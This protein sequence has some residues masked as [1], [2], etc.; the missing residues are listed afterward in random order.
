MIIQP[1]DLNEIRLQ[2]RRGE[3]LPLVIRVPYAF[4]ISQFDLADPMSTMRLRGDIDEWCE[5]NDVEMHPVRCH[6]GASKYPYTGY[7]QVVFATE[8]DLTMFKLKW[9]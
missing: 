2:A 9:L 4:V 7:S 6:S 1:G 5:K 3:Q 8:E